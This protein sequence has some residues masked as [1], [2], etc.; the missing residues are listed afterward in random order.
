MSTRMVHDPVRRGP[1]NRR[2][3]CA[4]SE[5]VRY[6]AISAARAALPRAGKVYGVNPWTLR[7][8]RENGGPVVRVG[9]L[10]AA[11]DMPHELLAHLEAIA[12]QRTVIGTLAALEDVARRDPY[13]EAEDTVRMQ[14]LLKVLRSDATRAVKLAA[15]E[16]AENAKRAD[17]ANDAR[18]LAEI[19]Q[20]RD[21]MLD[22][23]KGAK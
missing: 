18:A 13:V 21:N 19:R 16:E 12:L 14:E 1:A 2:P 15:L 7:E 6:A 9:E 5:S 4:P 23:R 3:V 10:L 17:A 20:Y 22:E 8:A 11:A